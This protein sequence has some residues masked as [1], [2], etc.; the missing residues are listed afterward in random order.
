M[1]YYCSFWGL[2]RLSWVVLL[3]EIT[4]GTVFSWELG[5]KMAFQPQVFFHVDSY[6]SVVYHYN[7]AAGFQGQLFLRGHI[8][9]SSIHTDIPVFICLHHT[10]AKQVSWLK[11]ESIW[12]RLYKGIHAKRWIHQEPLIFHCYGHN[13]SIKGSDI[14]K[15]LCLPFWL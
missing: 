5:K 9:Y 11:W 14:I 7:M 13:H 4:H 1:I 12:E 8:W 2:T 6:K 15:C 3:T 10:L